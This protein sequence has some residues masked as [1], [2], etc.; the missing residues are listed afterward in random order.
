MTIKLPKGYSNGLCSQNRTP[1][2]HLGQVFNPSPPPL[3]AEF[4]LNRPFY[5]QGQ[6]C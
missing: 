4:C 3:T 2:F 1:K 5:R 6:N